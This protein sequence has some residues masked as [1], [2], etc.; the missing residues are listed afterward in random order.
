[1][2]ILTEKVI[3]DFGYDRVFNLAGAMGPGL[4]RA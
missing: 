4:G 3:S 2:D 1:M